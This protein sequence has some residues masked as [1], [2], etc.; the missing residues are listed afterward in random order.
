LAEILSTGGGVRGALLAPRRQPRGPAYLRR[1]RIL[2]DLRRSLKRF[3]YVTLSRVATDLARAIKLHRSEPA[4]TP[5][6]ARSERLVVSM[7]T[8][9]QRIGCIL[10][11]LRSLLDQTCAAD[12]IVLALPSHSL[13]TGGPYPT[14]PPLPARVEVLR[15][16]DFGPAT[17]LLAVLRREPDA[18]IVAVDDDVIYPRDFLEIL[19][20]A[21]RRQPKCALGYRGCDLES[22]IDPRDFDHVFATALRA[23]RSVDLL[24]GTWGYLVPP[25]AFDEAVHDFSGFP[26]AVRWVDDIWFSGHLA[27]RKLPRY[28]VPAKGFPIE[29]RASFHAALT[30]G[31]NRMGKNDTAAIEAFAQWW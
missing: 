21:H 13:R 15:C 16:E 5:V 11:T 2:R 7:T 8:V 1:L 26:D 17:K 14:L 12:K 19:F 30:D 25:R 3:R 24:L 31:P 22:N 27:R 9:P 23:P 20:E 6:A 28:V 10:P 4:V 29:T 18:A